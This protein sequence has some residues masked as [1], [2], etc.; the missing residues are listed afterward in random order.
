MGGR[1]TGPH[2][3]IMSVT[4]EQLI[5]A[6]NDELNVNE[7]T[8]LTSANTRKINSALKWLS[9]MAKWSCLWKHETVAVG[10][11]DTSLDRPEGVRV[12]DKLE[13]AGYGPMTRFAYGWED[14][15]NKY[16]S[17]GTP[18][19]YIDRG[20]KI[21]FAPAA[22]QGF[23]IKIS[24][25]RWHEK[26]TDGGEAILFTDGFSEVLENKFIA[27]YLDGRGR[28]E[29][30]MFYHNRALAGIADITDLADKNVRMVRC[31]DL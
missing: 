2:L 31:N 13:L 28:H 22:R 21:F 14:Y 15:I 23:N 5:Q 17:T 30:A 7:S 10:Q 16:R 8:E 11:G 1:E 20:E 19:Q 9:S 4:I 26:I 24:Y 12:I 18:Q 6:V 3:P 27:E 29:K 25:W